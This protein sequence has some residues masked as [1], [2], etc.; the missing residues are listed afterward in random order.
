MESLK[1]KLLI[2][3]ARLLDPNFLQTVILLLQ[4][5]EKGAMGVI[6]NRALLVRL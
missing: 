5:D 3:I 2:A 4:H 1:G 6:L